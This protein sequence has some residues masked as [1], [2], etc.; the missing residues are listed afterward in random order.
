MFVTAMY[1]AEFGNRSSVDSNDNKTEFGILT[2][3][4]KSKQ[5]LLLVSFAMPIQTV[6]TPLYCNWTR[7]LIVK[8]GRFSPQFGG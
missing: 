5:K 1:S 2:K 8:S 4:Y 3:P 6:Y 7:C